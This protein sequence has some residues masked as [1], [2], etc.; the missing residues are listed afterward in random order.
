ML[1]LDG[2]SLARSGRTVFGGISTEIPEGAFIGLLGPNG[3][4]KTSLLRVIAG[5]QPPTSGRI[6]WRGRPNGF[7]RRWWRPF[8]GAR[9]GYVPQIPP[10]VAFPLSVI[11]LF[12]SI[13][14]GNRDGLE[15]LDRLGLPDADHRCFHTLSGGEKRRVLL[16]LALTQRPELLLLDEADSFLDREGRTLAGR[17]VAEWWKTGGGI[18]TVLT[19][20]H[21][22]E[23]F[24]DTITHLWHLNGGTLSPAPAERRPC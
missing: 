10:A 18:R 13:S 1:R 3:A 14:S 17:V 16:A 5:I 20:S 8:W 2:I 21:H 7:W 15:W 9:I 4:G 22:P 12:D 11:D 19:A 23:E 6:E 24:P